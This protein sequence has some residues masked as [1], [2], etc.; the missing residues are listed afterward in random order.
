V[1]T[2]AAL[3]H[4]TAVEAVLT[5]QYRPRRPVPTGLVPDPPSYTNCIA[6]LT[7]SAKSGRGRP[8]PTRARV[9]TQCE[10][11]HEELQRHILDILITDY[12]IAEEAIE[13]DIKATPQEVQHVLRRE[14]PTMAQL[15]RFL[16]ISGM[17]ASDERFLI[18]NKLLL[19]KL[20]WTVSPLRGHVGPESAQM[21]VRVDMSTTRLANEMTKRWTPQT[22]CRA[23][24]VVA[25]C[26][27]HRDVGSA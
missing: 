12:W 4:W 18:E 25:E 21:A 11:R 27:Q 6:Y 14:F 15:R 20:Q 23:G 1:L 2:K 8:K 10:Q 17:R 13:K 3:A 24:Y 22:T 5:Y 7:A 16:A 19:E 26:R 9:K